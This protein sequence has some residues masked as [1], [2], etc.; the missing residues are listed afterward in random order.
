MLASPPALAG[1]HSASPG[2]LGPPC[3]SQRS[4]YSSA[5]ELDAE[6][7]TRCEQRELTPKAMLGYSAG[8]EADALLVARLLITRASA[9]LRTS[10]LKVLTH[11]KLWA[12]W[13]R[14]RWGDEEQVVS[15]VVGVVVTTRI[16]TAFQPHTPAAAK[17]WILLDEDL[18]TLWL[19]MLRRGENVKII[20]GFFFE[21]LLG[22]RNVYIMRQK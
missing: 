5:A 16:A 6:V 3:S 15:E 8:G 13:E 10:T 20:E 7:M 12:E 2:V 21:S 9:A 14:T 1:T 18:E 4:S 17:F 11:I 19:E 22:I